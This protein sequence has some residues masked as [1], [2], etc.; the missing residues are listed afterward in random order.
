[1]ID[2]LFL[3]PPRRLDGSNYLFNNATLQLASFLTQNGL[4]VR[5]EP[6]VGADWKDR[7]EKAL[8][9]WK[10]RWRRCMRRWWITPAACPRS[11]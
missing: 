5:V 6:L 8:S 10:P 11:I 7:L 4:T 2:V 1:M 3:S 9:G